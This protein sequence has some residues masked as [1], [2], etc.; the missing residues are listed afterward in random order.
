MRTGSSRKRMFG[1][2]MQRMRRLWMSEAAH[3]VDD[4]EALDL[5]E[6][7]VDGEIAAQGVF[8]GR[9]VAVVAQHVQIVVAVLLFLVRTAPEGRGLDDVVVEADVGQPEAA[10]DQESS[11]GRS[12]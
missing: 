8:L 2:P 12:S 4:G 1:S 9:A 11:S 5:V 6:Q 7:A 10:P 3:V